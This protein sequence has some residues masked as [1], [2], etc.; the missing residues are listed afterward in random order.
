MDTNLFLK[1]ETTFGIWIKKYYSEKNTYVH[2]KN[3]VSTSEEIPAYHL[4]NMFCV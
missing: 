4:S 1:N 3:I 2:K